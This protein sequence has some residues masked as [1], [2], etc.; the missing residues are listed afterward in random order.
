MDWD[1][2]TPLS[3]AHCGEGG[4]FPNTIEVPQLAAFCR[5]LATSADA[6]E[7]RDLRPLDGFE[8]VAAVDRALLGVGRD[9]ADRPGVLPVVAAEGRRPRGDEEL[10][11]LRVV[12]E[13]S[14][15]EVVARAEG[16]ED[17]E[18]LLLLD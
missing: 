16:A 15:G 8:D 2:F 13:L 11:D 7:T 5:P 4:F 10:R 17:G 12:Q 18:H 3:V 9:V 1:S 6:E 14:H